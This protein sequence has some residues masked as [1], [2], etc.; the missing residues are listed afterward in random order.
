TRARGGSGTTPGV[1]RRTRVVFAVLAALVL[2][3]APVVA[4]SGLI[5]DD[6]PQPM[7]TPASTFPSGAPRKQAVYPG[8]VLT[9]DEGTKL[10][11]EKNQTVRFRARSA[12]DDEVHVHGYDR[13]FDAPASQTISVSFKA[14]I[15]GIF[16]IEFEQQG[17][18]IGELR[19]DPS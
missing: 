14:T 4:F 13:T 7:T 5:G 8:P 10:R 16:A 6:D 2:V 3:L 17:V 15:D 9:A 11:F 19:V 1:T 12:L 18:Q